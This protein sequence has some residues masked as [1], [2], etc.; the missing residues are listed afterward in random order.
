[1]GNGQLFKRHEPLI[2]NPDPRRID[3]RASV[4][5][6]F[7]AYKVRVYQ[8][9][10]TVDVFVIAD[11]SASMNFVGAQ[12]KKQTLL[13]FIAALANS[14]FE[15][16][17]KFGFIG[18]SDVI[19]QKYHLPAS[20][21]LHRL[22]ELTKQLVTMPSINSAVA[23]KEAAVYLPARRS[24]VFMVSD[25]HF[26]LLHLQATLGSLQ[27]HDVIP[28]VLWDEQE[29]QKLPD[30][31]LVTY[32]DVETGKSQLL[33]MRPALKQKIVKAYQQRQ[34]AIQA[35]CRG[36]GL[37]PLFLSQGYQAEPLNRYFQQRVA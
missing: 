23:L 2:A 10:S 11:L 22:A 3:I 35:G 18:C 7:N 16:G 19:D 24:L 20:R 25:F 21:H 14:A 26:P 29:Y 30:W 17:D 36:F 15:Y 33:F 6:P 13:K 31:G 28:L 1:M 9:P 8:Q 4:L 12:D 37:E 34:Q 5:D 32:A 27:N